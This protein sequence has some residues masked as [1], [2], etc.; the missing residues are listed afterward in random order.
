MNTSFYFTGEK[1][2]T[3]K[4]GPVKDPVE[5]LGDPSIIEESLL[6]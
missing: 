6:I 2:E 4:Q 5:V 1:I 3:K